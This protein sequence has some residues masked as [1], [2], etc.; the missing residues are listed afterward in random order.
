MYLTR[1]VQENIINLSKSYKVVLITGPRE[2]GK[3]QC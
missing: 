2:V 3:K 1:N